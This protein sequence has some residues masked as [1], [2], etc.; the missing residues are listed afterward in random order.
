MQCVVICLSI[1]LKGKLL[2]V[3]DSA[4][5]PGWPMC[6]W[7]Q[8]DVLQQCRQN[9]GVLCYDW[10]QEERYILPASS[11]YMKSILGHWYCF[12]T[13]KQKRRPR[14]CWS[15]NT[16]TKSN[17]SPDIPQ[18]FFCFVSIL[19]RSHCFLS[20][21]WFLSFDN[22]IKC[23]T[24]EWT[25]IGLLFLTYRLQQHPPVSDFMY[26]IYADGE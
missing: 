6:S 18:V 10:F 1:T 20:K 19:A 5:A 14:G 25:R 12:G 4:G 2:C 17:V 15:G 9:P 23:A 16:S 21:S 22:S 11:W 3:V 26:R 8:V 7:S 24:Y 13:Q